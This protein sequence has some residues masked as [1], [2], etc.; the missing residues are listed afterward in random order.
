[1]G[2]IAPSYEDLLAE[3]QRLHE[4]IERAL[5][6][7]STLEAERGND[8]PLIANLQARELLRGLLHG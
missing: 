3:I 1:M 8:V 2:P 5:A 7:R 6:L 4:G